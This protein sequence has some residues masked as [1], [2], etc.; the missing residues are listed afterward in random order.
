MAYRGDR[1]CRPRT[2]FH[3]LNAYDDG[4]TIVLEVVRHAKMFEREPH[5]PTEGAPALARW[6]VD[7]AAGKVREEDLDDRPQEFPRVD[8]RLVGRRHRYGYALGL[9]GR[10][11]TPSD[12][13]LKHDL[14]RGTTT[15]RSFGKGREAGEFVL[16]PNE[17]GAAEDDGALM[18]FVYDAATG[19]SDLMLL[20]AGSLETVASIHLPV[21]VPHGFHGNWVPA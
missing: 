9:A 19:R 18:G 5:G 15:T 3:P 21:R 13:I 4:D 16:E 8:E 11:A 20:D 10:G 1:G 6:T 2:L 14:V 7:L 12:T 17:P